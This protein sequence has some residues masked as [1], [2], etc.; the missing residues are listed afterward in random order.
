MRCARLK[1]VEVLSALV[2]IEQKKGGDV[3][4]KEAGGL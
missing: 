3:R 4:I 1:K 2:K